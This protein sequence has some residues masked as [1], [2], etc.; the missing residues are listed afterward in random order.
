MQNQPNPARAL[1][2]HRKLLKEG[3]G[4]RFKGMTE[5]EIIRA[6]KKPEKRFGAKSLQLVLDSDQFL[7]T[8]G[9]ERKAS[10]VAFLGLYANGIPNSDRD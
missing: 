8:Y 7:L 10:C 1:A 4:D 5:E 3:L 6:L 9:H 2:L